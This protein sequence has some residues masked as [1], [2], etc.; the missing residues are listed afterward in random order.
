MES[1][2]TDGSK[3]GC[4]QNLSRLSEKVSVSEGRRLPTVKAAHGS[5]CGIFFAVAE[6]VRGET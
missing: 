4:N 6:P 5:S 3:G 1:V 2:L